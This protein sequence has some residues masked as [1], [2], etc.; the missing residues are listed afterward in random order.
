[1]ILLSHQIRNKILNIKKNIIIII[2]IIKNAGGGRGKV[3]ICS[4][5]QNPESKAVT[6]TPTIEKETKDRESIVR[7]KKREKAD[8]TSKI[9]WSC[10]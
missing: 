7:D 5:D 8:Y 2:I 1:M 3:W 4:E 10:S 6:K 9:P